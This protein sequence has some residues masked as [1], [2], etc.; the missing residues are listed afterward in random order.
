[1]LHSRSRNSYMMSPRS[2]TAQPIGMPLRILKFAMDFLARVMMAFWPVI[3]PS[4]CAAVSSS[5]AFWLASPRPMLT[6]ILATL[7][8]AMM[9]FQ[10]K[11]FISAGVVSLRYLSCNRLFIFLDPFSNKKPKPCP[12]PYYLSKVV[13]QRRQERT[14]FPSARTV[15]AMRVCLPQLEQTIITFDAL[16]GPSF[17]TMPPLTFLF[18]F[19]PVWR[20]IMWACSSIT[21]FLSGLTESTRPVLP[22]LLPAITFTRSPLRI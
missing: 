14:F 3:W 12:T 6:V 1:M 21:V 20:L 2:V 10:P 7:G 18:G 17:S 11:R 15:W 5:F 22:A 13:P 16:I 4:S 19:G 8:T 9:F